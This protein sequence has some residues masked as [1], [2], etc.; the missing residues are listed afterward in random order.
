VRL[1]VDYW[2]GLSKNGERLRA[3][4]RKC[5][6]AWDLERTCRAWIFPTFRGKARRTIRICREIEGKMGKGRKGKSNDG[7]RSGAMF[8]RR[9]WAH[10]AG[11]KAAMNGRSPRSAVAGKRVGPRDGSFPIRAVARSGDRPK[12]GPQHNGGSVGRPAKT[13]RETDHYGLRPK[14]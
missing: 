10:G 14:T 5:M 4:L 6:G 3:R 7:E 8:A 11:R 12:R 2:R 9:A 1:L 13:R